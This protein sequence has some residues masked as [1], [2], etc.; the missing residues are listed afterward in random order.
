MESN[1]LT[2]NELKD[3][4]FSLK[5]NKSPGYDEISFNVIKKRFGEP[6]DPLKFIFELS[7]EK[8][9][10]P[11]DLKIARVTPIFKGGNLSNLGH[12]RP[13]SVLPCFSK[14]PEP[15]MHNRIYKYLLENNILYSKQFA[16]QFA[17]QLTMQ[18]FNLLIRY[19]KLL[20]I[21]CIHWVCLLTFQKPLLQ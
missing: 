8:G 18:L 4:F 10:F 1:S 20:K 5:I 3:A 12:Y 17:I 16:F 7:L 21:T 15:I 13:I 2:I 9:I 19:F 11:D 14:I 6:Y